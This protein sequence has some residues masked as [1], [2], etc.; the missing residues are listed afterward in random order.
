MRLRRRTLPIALRGIR[1]RGPRREAEGSGA[2]RRQAQA[3]RH[4]LTP[5]PP[6]LAPPALAR[7]SAAAV[8]TA[9][10]PGGDARGHVHGAGDR[11]GEARRGDLRRGR[12]RPE[13]DRAGC[14]ADRARVPRRGHRQR[15][16][17]RLGVLFGAVITLVAWSLWARDHAARRHSPAARARRPRPTSGSSSAP[18]ASPRRP[19]CSRSRPSSRSSAGSSP[20]RRA[21]GSSR[22]WSWPCARRSTTRAPAGR[23]RSARSASSPTPRCSSSSACCSLYAVGGL[24]G[25]AG[26]SGSQP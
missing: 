6:T 21:S 13:R 8:Y 4:G 19:A 17:R 25:G 11:R 15:R 12:A 23:S 16:A 3:G 1:H 22:R 9:A 10:T 2:E 14:V 7:R 5:S 26:G 24:H 20:S 18:S